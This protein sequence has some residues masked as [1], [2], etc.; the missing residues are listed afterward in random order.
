[1]F[2]VFVNNLSLIDCNYNF[3]NI[4]FS[5]DLRSIKPDSNELDELAQV[6]NIGITQKIK[7]RLALKSLYEL[8]AIIDKEETEAIMQMTN[9]LKSMENAI[10]LV[11]DTEKSSAISIIYNYIHNITKNT[12]YPQLRMYMVCA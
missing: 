10:K 9:K 3:I 1:M 7:L 11:A 6:C 5:D 12:F 4:I 8:S 2:N